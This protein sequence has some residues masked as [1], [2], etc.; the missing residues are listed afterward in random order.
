MKTGYQVF[1][2]FRIVQ[3]ERDVQVL[4]A[5]K[6]FFGCGVVRRNHDDRYELRIRKLDCLKRV[7]EFFEKYPLKTKKNI[8]F[9]KFRR[10]LLLMERGEHLTKEG[11]IKILEIAI[12]MNTGNHQ[13]LEETLREIKR[14]LDEDTVHPQ[15]ERL[16]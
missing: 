7:V 12:E 6:K 16:G 8:D 10:I 5:L 2:E 9:K 3:H 11:L 14:G 13:R 15:T 4:Y 1:P